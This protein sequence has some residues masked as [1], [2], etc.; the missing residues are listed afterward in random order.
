[1]KHYATP[2]DV[3]ADHLHSRGV[4]NYL[5]RAAQFQ[6]EAQQK[7][8]TDNVFTLAELR[9]VSH[10][11]DLEQECYTLAGTCMTMAQRATMRAYQHKQLVAVLCATAAKHQAQKHTTYREQINRD[12]STAN[13]RAN[14]KAPPGQLVT[15]SPIA[16]CAA[17][18]APGSDRHAHT[19]EVMAIRS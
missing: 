2:H 5:D 16:T 15:L 17:S 14:C 11:H 19:H 7:T 9:E 13:N 12:S 6:S 8:P 18:N 10:L 1:V 4:A 3:T